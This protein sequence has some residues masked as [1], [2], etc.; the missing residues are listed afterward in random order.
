MH[1]PPRLPSID[2]TLHRYVVF[3]ATSLTSSPL[4]LTGSIKLAVNAEQVR[5]ICGDQMPVFCINL[6]I[7]VHQLYMIERAR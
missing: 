2:P 7:Y 5:G 1:R 4:G 3:A 6:D